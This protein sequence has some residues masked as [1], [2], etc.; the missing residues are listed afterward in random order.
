M[1]GNTK[2][3]LINLGG[4]GYHTFSVPAHIKRCGTGKNEYDCSFK[5]KT[6]KCSV[7]KGVVTN[8]NW[9]T[10]LCPGAKENTR[11]E[12]KKPHQRNQRRNDDLFPDD[13]QKIYKIIDEELL[14]AAGEVALTATSDKHRRKLKRM[15]NYTM[16]SKNH[17]DQIA[18]KLTKGLQQINGLNEMISNMVL[19]DSDDLPDEETDGVL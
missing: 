17:W 16:K 15:F 19:T 11:T 12:Y 9:N 3:H 1:S 5:G 10:E 14:G 6:T 8:E 2:Y 4:E 13:L 18:D 7:C